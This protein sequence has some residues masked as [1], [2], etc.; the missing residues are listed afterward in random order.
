MFN[1]LAVLGKIIGLVVL[2][3]T[4]AFANHIDKATAKVTCTSYSLTVSASELTPG[5]SYT[6]NYR[7]VL[8]PPSGSPTT[9][10]GSIPF[11]G[12]SSGTFSK[13]VTK[14]LGPLTSN[15]TLSGTATLQGQNTT[16]FHLAAY[17][18]RRRP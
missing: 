5:A 12:P 1:R 17:N 2:F 13:T 10:T 11:T 9:I 15:Y 6:I 16:S 4:Q 7:I 3:G 8:T 18:A 14:A